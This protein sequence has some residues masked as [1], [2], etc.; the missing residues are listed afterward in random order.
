MNCVPRG[1]RRCRSRLGR[2]T[3]L[4]IDRSANSEWKQTESNQ[5]AR[6]YRISAPGKKR[7]AEEISR[8]S[9]TVQVMSG[10]LKPAESD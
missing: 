5:R 8:W 3:Q 6:Y 9:R 10:I 1:A 4:G 2:F 7:L